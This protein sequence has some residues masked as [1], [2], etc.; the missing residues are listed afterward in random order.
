[1]INRFIDD[2][3]SKGAEAVLPQ[4]LE[5]EWL[6]TIYLAA[7]AFLKVAL[8]QDKTTP[9]DEI[10]SDEG[11]LIMLS[12]VVEAGQHID[13]YGPDG[14]PYTIP[15][16]EMFERITCYAL[17]VVF[18]WIAREAGIELTVPTVE[19]LFDRDRFFEVEED[20]P[21]LT[22]ILDKLINIQ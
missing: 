22:E 3:I 9:E 5:K 20:F 15:E 10:L 7:K 14:E 8:D 11:S 18:E 17:A 4:N 6:D 21:E 16:D 19:N 2:V 1:M 13:G 12:A